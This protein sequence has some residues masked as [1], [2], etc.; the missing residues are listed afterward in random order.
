M[1]REPPDGIR[2]RPIAREPQ[3]LA[4]AAAPVN[5]LSSERAR[6]AWL[7]HPVRPAEER[8]RVGLVPDPLQ[9]MLADVGELEA[10]DRRRRLTGQHVAVR[11]DHHRRPAPPAHARLRELFVEVGEHPEDVELGA[12]TLAEALDLF[13]SAPELLPRWQ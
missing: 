1:R 11:S 6:A 5:L 2:G 8:E 9:R 3:R 13:L 7:L 4:A 10:R 12:D